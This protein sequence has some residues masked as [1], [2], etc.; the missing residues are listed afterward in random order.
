[1]LQDGPADPLYG[2]FKISPN[3]RREL[4]AFRRSI[5]SGWYVVATGKTAERCSYA[6]VE[7]AKCSG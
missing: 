2:L 3:E 4:G 5:W 6:Q 7:A 1:M